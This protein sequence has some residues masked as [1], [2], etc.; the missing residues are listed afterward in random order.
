LK[1]LLTIDEVTA[2]WGCHRITVLR[3]MERELLNWVER[4]VEYLFDEEEVRLLKN[5]SIARFPHLT[6]KR[7]KSDLTK[8][9]KRP[10]RPRNRLR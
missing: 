6:V 2:L 3:M 9:R 10:T 4:G 1:K 7:R 8:S 5:S